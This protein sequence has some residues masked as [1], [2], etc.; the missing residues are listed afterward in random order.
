M[1]VMSGTIEGQPVFSQLD[2][3]QAA[4][5]FAA[6]QLMQTVSVTDG[7]LNVSFSASVDN[8]KLSGIEV[9]PSG[10]TVSPSSFDF[11]SVEVGLGSQ[12]QTFTLT[13]NLS[14]S[15]AVSSVTLSG[16]NASSFN[17]AAAPPY[18]IPPQ[19]AVQ[20]SASF[21]PLQ[22]GP[23]AA[24]I[25]VASDAPGSPIQIQ[26]SGTGTNPTSGP[27]L[28]F[29]PSS[30]DFGSHTVGVPSLPVSVQIQ[31]SGDENLVVSGLSITGAQAGDFSA[32]ATPPYT[33]PP[34]GMQNI[35]LTFTAGAVGSR[36]AGLSV[37]SNAST[38]PD[39][40]PLDGTGISGGGTGGTAVALIN[41]GGG[42]YTD[43]LSRQ[44]SAD[45]YYSGGDTY[46]TGNSIT[47]TP[48]P[49]LYQ[50]ERW[51][52]P[53]SYS[54]PIV[55]GDYT[56]VLHFA[57]IYWNAAGKRVFDVSLEGVNVL[58]DLDLW[59]VAGHDVAISYSFPVTVADGALSISL[60]AS[61]DNAKLSAIEVLTAG[62]ASGPRLQVTPTLHDFGTITVGNSSA[63]FSFQL[64]NIG[65][66]DLTISGV[67]VG[68]QDAAEFSTSASAP[69]ILTPFQS[70][71]VATTFSPLS[72][73]AKQATLDIASDDPTSPHSVQL[74]GQGQSPGSGGGPTIRIN[75]GG[76]QY[77]DGGGKVWQADTYFQ[78]GDTYSTTSPIQQTTEDSLYQSERWGT[79]FGYQ[80]PLSNGSYDVTLHFAEIYWTSAGSRIFDVSLEGQP[81]ISGL[82]LI[83]TVGANTA[84]A[85]TFPVTVQDGALSISLTASADAA[86]ISA[87]E[88]VGTSGGGGGLAV[89]PSSHN[90]GPVGVGLMGAPLTVELRNDSSGPIVVSS[91]TISGTGAAAFTATSALPVT[92]S[93]SQSAYVG[94]DFAP[95]AVG[96]Y[97]ASLDIVSDAPSSPHAVPL[98][99]S[100]VGSAGEYFINVGGGDY[101]DGANQLWEADKLFVGGDTY[102]T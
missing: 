61:A 30:V 36:S 66:Q 42:A 60:N 37:V 22:A 95:T 102:T 71:Q 88:I 57:E 72:A 28:S 3:V 67:S 21:I 46:S 80:V 20:F 19:G 15:V 81:V 55:N 68:G 48:D 52:S 35:D 7:T 26:L 98:T 101:L 99:G 92:L 79:A 2:L 78:G 86:K 17:L 43:S 97:S 50:S 4:G 44:W 63:P 40:L 73:G 34:S 89:L 9:V 23:L 10:L 77:T 25:A 5:S 11:G 75:A 27:A 64:K 8:A 1:R 56:V 65:D 96:P 33:I 100:G 24:T 39:V 70:V 69:Y 31:N 62:S 87:I 6:Y 47:N 82:D 76:G 51:G 41:V 18:N 29:S 38:S 53:F 59:S 93:P 14:T 32:S 13:N 12:P 84:Y 58:D 83:A 16:S 74:S 54:I 85:V 94:V 90:F 91:A 45:Q 49:T